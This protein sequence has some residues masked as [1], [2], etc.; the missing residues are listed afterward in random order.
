MH[1]HCNG[2][3][4]ICHYIMGRKVHCEN[5]IIYSITNLSRSQLTQRAFSHAQMSILPSF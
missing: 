2:I 4:Y 5:S 3:S 1:A